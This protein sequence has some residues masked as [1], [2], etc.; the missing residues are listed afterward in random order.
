VLTWSPTVGRYP[1]ARRAPTSVSKSYARSSTSAS[2]HRVPKELTPIGSAS[3]G[4]A[5]PAGTVTFGYPATA[6]GVEVA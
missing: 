6:A 5:K 4:P 1:G 3:R 2:S